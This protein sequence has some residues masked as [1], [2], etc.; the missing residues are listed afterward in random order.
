MD[1]YEPLELIGSGSFGVIRKVRRKSDQKV[2]A[3]K[4]IDYRKMSEKEKKQLVSEVNILRE[5]RHPN[6]VRYYERYVDRENC[7]IYI[8][9]EYCEGGDLAAIIKRCKSEEK[10]IPEDIIWNLFVQLLHAVNECHHGRAHPPILHRDIKP[11]NVFL[12]A[13]QNV[14]LGDFGLSR[15]IDSPE[16]GYAQ[17]Y[18]GTPFYMSPELVNESC[19]NIK[20]DIWALG[21]LIFELCALEPP[22]QANTQTGLAMKIRQGIVPDLPA[23]Y[24]SDLN[25]TVKTMLRISHHKRPNASDFLATDRVRIFVKEHELSKIHL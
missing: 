24:S 17:T 3:C 7:L 14:K 23:P 10:R 16:N 4:E 2:L 25:R 22:F 12:D 15:V 1:A 21:C 20:S 8:L 11:D 19:Y 13:A 6:I 5:L 18:V 9:M